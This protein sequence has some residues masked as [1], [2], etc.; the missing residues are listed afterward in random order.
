MLLCKTSFNAFVCLVWWDFS[1]KATGIW[2]AMTESEPLPL[3]SL[4]SPAPRLAWDGEEGVF[5]FS[6]MC[7]FIV[8]SY[9]WCSKNCWVPEYRG[10]EKRK[11]LTAAL[12][13]WEKKQHHWVVKHLCLGCVIFTTVFSLSI[14]FP[15]CWF[16]G[17]RDKFP[18]QGL[19]FCDTEYLLF[20]LSREYLE[21]PSWD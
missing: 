3:L 20:S 13:L 15:L 6:K 21:L 1:L 8:Y 14:F 5:L 11:K 2:A 7:F 16:R 17:E 10:V 4:L 12:E 9:F 18:L 19:R